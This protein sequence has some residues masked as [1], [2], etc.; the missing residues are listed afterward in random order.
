M[1]RLT[2]AVF[3]TAALALAASLY[4]CPVTANA[5][6]DNY[7]TWCQQNLAPGQGPRGNESCCNNAGGEF[8]GGQ[9]YDPAALHPLPTAVPTVTQQILPPRIVAPAG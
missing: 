2:C 7:Y 1:R 4:A 8:S 6:D 3:F 5:N 9:C